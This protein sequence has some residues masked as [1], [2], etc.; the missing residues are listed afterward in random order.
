MIK[1]Y[2][3]FRLNEESGIRNI[4]KIVSDHKKI[5]D[6]FEIWFHLDLD[7]VCSA[8]AMK[9]YI[10]DYG[11][12]LVDTH[13]IQYGGIEYAIKNKKEGSLCCLVD[14]AH[15]K[16]MYQIHTDHHDKQTGVG[17]KSSHFK[18]ARSNA[19]T[20]S[21]EVS[22]GNIFG[23]EDIK[24]IQTVDSADFLKYNIVPDDIQNSVFSYKKDKSAVKNRFLMGLVTNR[25]LL[26][27]KSKRI[28]VKSLDGKRNHVNKNL[29]ECLVLDS[30]P[31]LY[32]IFNNLRHYINNAV[33]SEWS[34]KTRSHNTPMKLATPEEIMSNLASYINTRKP[35]DGIDNK[36]I[37]FIE[38]YNIVKQYGIGSVFK[39][40]AYDRYVVFKNYP[41]ADFVCT[42][43]PM[44]LIQVS[45]NP[46][47]EKALKEV[48]LGE[49]A[50]E[51]LNKYKY[52]LSNI[53]VPISDI[54]KINEYEVDKMRNRYGSDYKAIGF[55]FDDL[56]SFY[57][58]S[59]IS[60]PNRKSGDN[61]TRLI[62]DLNDEKNNDV[63]LLKEWMDKPYETWPDNIIREISWLK[64]P[65]W[66][67]IT[68]ASGGH[69]SITNIQGLN[70][71]SSRR[72]LLRILFKTDNYTDIMKMIGERFIEVMKVKIDAARSG[73]K[74]SYDTGDVTLNST[75]IAESVDYFIRD[76]N[77]RKVSKEEFIEFGMNYQFEP[78]RD[79]ESG[80]KIE[81]DD[82]RVVGYY[83]NFKN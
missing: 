60:L 55:T 18:P 35:V 83:E 12:K 58:K 67:I 63:K 16:G 32:S 29:L 70:Y 24:L 77:M 78:K 11:L 52:Q 82:N 73:R 71:L 13:I 74:I 28:T 48:N 3:K 64:I 25:L 68:E 19:E 54:K 34:M 80:F 65:I 44:G 41:K 76:E 27:F 15:G 37:E 45:C 23:S 57:S 47:K 72:D 36:D 8:L 21:G 66:D 42:I 59:I 61:K 5:S 33:S 81:I 4:S 56:K 62:L 10:E 2:F 69:P 7:G 22:P 50:K 46:F 51:V 75:A 38:N 6:N 43:F 39:T 53:N 14:F 79:S 9:K 31:S 1:D 17:T 40:G 26:S 30:S 20:I 49:I